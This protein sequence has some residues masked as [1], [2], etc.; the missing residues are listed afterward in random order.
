MSSSSQPC[1][2]HPL[3]DAARAA[4]HHDHEKASEDFLDAAASSDAGT[5]EQSIALELAS[6][7]A[8]LA[9]ARNIGRIATVL[10]RTGH[11]GQ[12]FQTSRES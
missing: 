9:T 12:R 6:V 1:D 2:S 8:A 4:A 3:A 10:E 11:N 7:E 5:D